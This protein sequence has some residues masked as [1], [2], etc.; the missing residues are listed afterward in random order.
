VSGKAL[1]EVLS[2]LLKE[3]VVVQPDR[4]QFVYRLA[5]PKVARKA[6]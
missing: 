5:R 4:Q 6:T 3:G 1:G 2:G